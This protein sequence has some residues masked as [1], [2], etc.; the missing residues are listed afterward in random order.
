MM[1]GVGIAQQQQ[2]QDLYFAA[3]KRAPSIMID[4]MLIA[5]QTRHEEF[6]RFALMEPQLSMT[7]RRRWSLRV[8]E[9]REWIGVGVG[10]PSI[11]MAEK[12]EFDVNSLGHGYYMIS[13]NG[14]TWSHDNANEQCKQRS[15]TF[16]TGDVINIEFDPLARKV[17]F[18]KNNLRTIVELTLTASQDDFCGVANLGGDGDCVEILSSAEF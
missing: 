5:H 10:H 18:T 11:L 14:F 4:R 12:Y 16:G 3:D 1:S 2:S 13:H 9:L 17:R 8:H 7:V 15:F 6:K